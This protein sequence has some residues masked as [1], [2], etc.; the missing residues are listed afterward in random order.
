M[1]LQTTISLVFG[2]AIVAVA[3]IIIHTMA[4][5][6]DLSL[7][8]AVAVELLALRVA[9]VKNDI[10]EQVTLLINTNEAK[11]RAEVSQVRVEADRRVD[12]SFAAG[13]SHQPRA[14]D[15]VMIAAI[16]KEAVHAATDAATPPSG[17]TP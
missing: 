4:K 6:L 16:A 10:N 5:A 12:A 13:Q 1:N 11:H 7:R 15:L 3:V 14:P 2:A 17:S 9:D 8:T